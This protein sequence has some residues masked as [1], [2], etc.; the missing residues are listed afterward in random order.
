MPLKRVLLPLAA[1]LWIASA[2]A[3]DEGISPRQSYQRVLVLFQ[4]GHTF[5][6][7]EAVAL[8]DLRQ[9][10]D[11][12]GDSDLAAS[13]DLLRL[14]AAAASHSA[15]PRP[16]GGDVRAMLNPFQGGLPA[17]AHS[18]SHHPGAE[19]PADSPHN[20]F[21]RAARTASVWDGPTPDRRGS[22]VS[23]SNPLRRAVLPKEEEVEPPNPFA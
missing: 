7:P 18:G 19:A 22:T 17:A 5:T 9:K 4:E 10:L 20:P 15:L 21:P 11:D 8:E 12:S 2:W 16:A 23:S 14:G 6:A 3:A 13:L 1:L